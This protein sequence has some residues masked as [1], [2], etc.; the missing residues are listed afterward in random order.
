MTLLFQS[1]MRLRVGCT[2]ESLNI[3]TIPQAAALSSNVT[4]SHSG[5]DSTDPIVYR[6]L[7]SRPYLFDISPASG[8]L[9]SGQSTVV[10]ITVHLDKSNATDYHSNFLNMHEDTFLI[11]S[12]TVKMVRVIAYLL[13]LP[14]YVH[15]S[16]NM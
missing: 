5:S 11:Q 12:A 4:L 7:A 6:A 16:S 14:L 1:R 10:R 3:S 13:S 15:E 2:V 8:K 9:H